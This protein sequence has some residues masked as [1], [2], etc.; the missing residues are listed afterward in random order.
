MYVTPAVRV[1][2]TGK[3]YELLL[4][5]ISLTKVLRQVSRK[6]LNTLQPQKCDPKIVEMADCG[7]TVGGRCEHIMIFVRSALGHKI[8]RD[9]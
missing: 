8:M 1:N 6:L 2:W 7:L 3:D 4:I 5:Q 9:V